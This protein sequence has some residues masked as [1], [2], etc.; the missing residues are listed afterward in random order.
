[1][2]HRIANAQDLMTGAFERMLESESGRKRAAGFVSNN[3]VI[4]RHSLSLAL[5][6]PLMI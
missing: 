1:V 4:N 5:V 3:Y 2:N 6:E